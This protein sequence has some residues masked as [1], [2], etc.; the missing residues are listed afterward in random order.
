MTNTESA[1]K[2]TKISIKGWKKRYLCYILVKQ[3]K[4]SL[5]VA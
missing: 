3:R 4:S 2:N 1:L 5:V